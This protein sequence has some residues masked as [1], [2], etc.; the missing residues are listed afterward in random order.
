MKSWRVGR[1]FLTGVA[2]LLTAATLASA[3]GAE[4]AKSGPPPSVRIRPL[5]LPVLSPSGQVERYTQLEVTLEVKDSLKLP[6]VQAAIPKLH[7]AILAEMYRAI[8]EGFVIR[9]AVANAPAVRRHLLEVSNRVV[10]KDVIGRVLITPTTR[11][12]AWP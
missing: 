9:G 10:G 4:E 5:M 7:D 8:D 1:R 12:S 6:D 2:A 3:A 11:Q